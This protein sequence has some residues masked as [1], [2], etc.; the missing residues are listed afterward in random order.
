MATIVRGLSVGL[1]LVLAFAG[2]TRAQ[3]R[4]QDE[5][6]EITDAHLTGTET[7]GKASI[8]SASG[9]A[10]APT[11]LVLDV[12]PGPLQR[13]LARAHREGHVVEKVV[14][15]G[16]DARKKTS[17]A[18]PVRR[19]SVEVERAAVVSYRQGVAGSVRVVLEPDPSAPRRRSIRRHA[20]LLDYDTGVE[21]P[22]PG[23][24]PYALRVAVPGQTI[25]GGKIRIV[26]KDP[27]ATEPP[28]NALGRVLSDSEVAMEEITLAVE[29]IEYD[30]RRRVLVGRLAPATGPGGDPDVWIGF[31]VPL[32]DF[33]MKEISRSR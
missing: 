20:R 22:R 9:A 8:V 21:I 29:R 6:I 33:V 27:N 1:A 5:W 18:E 31:E 19:P 32:P 17:G 23:R 2:T 12:A 3:D 14:V 4:D 11:R 30:R 26:L 13:V 16:W 24:G 7:T 15:R 25:S 28:V 10:N